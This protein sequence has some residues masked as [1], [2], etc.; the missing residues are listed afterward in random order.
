MDKINGNQKEKYSYSSNWIKSLETKQHWIYYWCQQKLMEGLIQEGDTILEIGVGSGFAANY[1][2][3]KG[4]KVITLDIDAG[5]NPD[6]HANIVEHEFKSK[7]DHVMAFEILEHIPFVEFCEVVEKVRTIV[8]GYFFLSLPRNEFLLL[9]FYLKIPI[10]KSMSYRL[11]V[12]RR[13]IITVNHH[14]EIDY[15]VYSKKVVEKQFSSV[16]F[17]KVKHFQEKSIYY[18]AFN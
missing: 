15:S 16:G 12:K 11:C 17:E 6:I 8:N 18:Y 9:D 5:K 2:K 14:W 10:F 13:R 3:S 7:F 4:F 1:L